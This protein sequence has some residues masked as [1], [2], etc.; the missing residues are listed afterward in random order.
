MAKEFDKKAA[1]EELDKLEKR[2][3]VI[4]KDLQY[5]RKKV[6]TDGKLS[7][8]ELDITVRDIDQIVRVMRD[9][10]DVGH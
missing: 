2:I 8:N 6:E 10:T 4:L 7:A 1:L 5:L 9:R 3:D